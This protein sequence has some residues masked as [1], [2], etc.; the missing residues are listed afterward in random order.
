MPKPQSDG[1]PEFTM[2]LAVEPA[3]PAQI[4]RNLGNRGGPVVRGAVDPR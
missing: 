4:N 1:L 2:V 3:A